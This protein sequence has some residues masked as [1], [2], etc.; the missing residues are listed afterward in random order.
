MKLITKLLANRL[1]EVIVNLVHQNQYG[2]IKIRTIQDCLAWALEYIHICHKS[3]KDLVI[4]KLDFGKAFDKIEHEAIIKVMEAK[5]F[6]NKWRSW[7]KS[8]LDSGTSAVQLNGVPGKTFHCKRGVR[9]GNPL[10]PLLF[11]LAADLLQSIVNKAKNLN[12]IKSPVPLQHTNDFPIIQYADDTILV[13]EA[14]SRQ[15]L[16]LKALLYTFGESIGLK[17]NYSKSMMVPINTSQ[18]KIAHLATTFNCTVGSLPFTYLGLPLSLSKPKAIDFSPIV[19]KCERRLAA[20]SIYLNQA[21]RLEI[22]NSVL[23]AMPTFCM[24]TFLLHQKILDQIDKYRKLCLWRGADTN[25][26]HRPKAA[27]PMV[28]QDR[29]EGGLG[30]VNLK[31]QNEALLLKHLHKF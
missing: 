24:S 26:K 23:T 31:S 5:G 22:T 4:L 2:F 1:Q 20:T 25:A 13:M 10:S 17:V 11:V 9:Q 27:W 16:A 28:C 6:G 19:T 29:K 7:I 21:E 18:E 14:C 8:I 3:K 30:L 15:I 12:L